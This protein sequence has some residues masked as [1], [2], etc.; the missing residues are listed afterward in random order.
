[1]EE[2]AGGFNI[3]MPPAST[4]RSAPESAD[5]IYSI[6]LSLHGQGP[7]SKVFLTA[8]KPRDG[9]TTL[10]SCLGYLAIG[11]SGSAGMTTYNGDSANSAKAG[12][13]PGP[14]ILRWGPETFHKFADLPAEIRIAIWQYTLPDPY[15]RLGAIIAFINFDLERPRAILPSAREYRHTC[16]F[17]TGLASSVSTSTILFM[18][19]YRDEYGDSESLSPQSEMD[20]G[21]YEQPLDDGSIGYGRAEVLSLMHT[22]AESRSTIQEV[23]VLDCPSILP[24]K[25]MPWMENDTVYL[26]KHGNYPLL[27]W[28]ESTPQN[29]DILASIYYLALDVDVSLLKELSIH[30]PNV[31]FDRDNDLRDDRSNPAFFKNFPCLKSLD[32]L[33]DPVN[34]AYRMTG[35]LVLYAPIETPV[36][37]LRHAK[38]SEVEKAFRAKLAAIHE[39]DAF[40][41][42]LPVVECAVVC[43]KKPKLQ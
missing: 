18:R 16:G 30:L 10:E 1:M 23:Y 28:I 17:S 43:W 39:V 7:L 20:G 15:H 34:A 42:G 27:Q 33:I 31:A 21:F 9:Y 6:D 22:C 3:G 19:L 36:G 12:P 13:A 38:P 5:W 32:L 24:T 8:S 37:K 41:N 29:P 26:T 4:D 2:Y 14:H 35:R 11:I 25:V 40:S